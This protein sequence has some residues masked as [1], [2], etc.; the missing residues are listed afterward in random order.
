MIIAVN[1]NSAWDDILKRVAKDLHS[2]K[3]KPGQVSP[4]MIREMA[5]DIFKG[6][7]KG[8][9]STITAT[10]NI[11]QYTILQKMR[12]NVFVFSGFKNYHELKEISLLLTDNNG[13]IR[14]FSEF[15]KD[16]RTIDK[17]YNTNYLRAE[18]DHAISSGTMMAKFEKF[19]AEADIFPMLRYRALHDGRTRKEH[20]EL[21][22]ATY[23]I[24]HE[25]WKTYYPPNGWRCRCDVEQ[26]EAQAIREPKAFPVLQPMFRNNVAINGVVFPKQ[27][28]YFE[29]SK[30]NKKTKDEIRLEQKIERIAKLS[31]PVEWQYD[32]IKSYGNGGKILQHILVDKNSNDYKRLLNIAKDKAKEGSIVEIL[33]IIHKDDIQ[34]REKL[35]P[36]Y[37]KNPKCPD[38]RIDGLFWEEECPTV[39]K[40]WADFRNRLKDR[41]LEG[42]KQ[43]ENVIITMP[44]YITEEQQRDIAVTKFADCHITHNLLTICFKFD[45]N[46][47]YW[48]YKDLIEE[49]KKKRKQ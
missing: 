42:S 3:L 22:G 15:L 41:I 14:P 26:V 36:N 7:T 33:P 44:K 25:F 27:H 2:G 28:P 39:S 49:V 5:Q 30:N 10:P 20:L 24:N 6:V 8:F 13:K 47:V 29:I 16:V 32:L 23:P 11:E 48:N 40:K 12:E 18:Y 31:M 21:D 1:M 35:Y 34:F 9:N 19:K 46:Y 38:L 37:S 4:E 45:N 43:A 17:T